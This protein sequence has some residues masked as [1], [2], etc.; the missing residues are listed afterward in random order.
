MPSCCWPVPRA[1]TMLN[2]IESLALCSCSSCNS[3]CG[4]CCGTAW[5]CG[6]GCCWTW[7]G[8]GWCCWD[9]CGFGWCC[10]LEE[11]ARGGDTPSPMYMV[12]NP[13]EV[14]CAV[15]RHNPAC[16][17]G[18]ITSISPVGI[19]RITSHE[20]PSS[21]NKN[22]TASWIIQ[23]DMLFESIWSNVQLCNS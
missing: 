3:G 9:G 18:P 14:G 4:C 5:C 19:P 10:S 13:E 22:G 7:C 21:G 15:K 12:H 6:C 17:N 8:F 2:P 16:C 11:G 20:Y 23:S 1:A